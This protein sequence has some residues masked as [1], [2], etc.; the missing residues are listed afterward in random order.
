[1]NG[2]WRAV[3]RKELTDALR[4]RRALVSALLFPL[5]GP[6]LMGLLFFSI[7]RNFASD[8]LLT[9]VVASHASEP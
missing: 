9:I 4:D 6:V 7:E 5:I 2:Q 8:D 3:V 1:M